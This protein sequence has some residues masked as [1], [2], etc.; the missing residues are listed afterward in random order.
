[1]VSELSPQQ[2]ITPP[3]EHIAD[4]AFAEFIDA[5][6]ELENLRERVPFGI[7][8]FTVSVMG[9]ADRKRCQTLQPGQKADDRAD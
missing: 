3:A 7:G 1:M 5:H 9:S 4:G 8:Q 2:N 6:T